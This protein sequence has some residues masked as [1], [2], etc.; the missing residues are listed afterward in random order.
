M[1]KV[2]GFTLIEV[3]VVLAVVAILAAILVPTIEKNINDAKRT[4][5]SN[6][7]QVIGAAMSSYFKDVGTWPG[8]GNDVLWTNDGST[9][10]NS[11]TTTNNVTFESYLIN[12]PSGVS[13]WRGPY[14]AEVKADPWGY[15]YMCNINA[16]TNS[17]LAL[18]VLSG[19]D[20][21]DID[22][23]QNLAVNGTIDAGDIGVRLR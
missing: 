20:D 9:P 5:A 16:A 11:W 22:T 19:G 15:K 18:F 4:R 8:Q 12:Q 13:N 23:S 21:N 14:L 2:R 17:N 10:T 3:V 7:V 6:E 1:K